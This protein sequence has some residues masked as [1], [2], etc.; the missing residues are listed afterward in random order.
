MTVIVLDEAKLNWLAA[1]HIY[2]YRSGTRPN[3]NQKLSWLPNVEV[4]P[5]VAYLHV[6]V[7]PDAHLGGYA[8]WP[9]GAFSYSFS[10]LPTDTKVGRYCSIATGVKVIGENHPLNRLSSSPFTYDLTHKI[11][12]QACEDLGIGFQS[13]GDPIVPATRNLAPIIN[14]DVWVG[15]DVL[16]GRGITIGNGAV[17]AAGSV[18]TE[19]VPAYAIVGGAPARLIRYRFP[20]Q[21]IE[22]LLSI[23]WWNYAFPD[24]RGIDMASDIQQ[25]LALLEEK[26]NLQEIIPYRPKKLRNSDLLAVSDEPSLSD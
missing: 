4:E 15:A 26:I 16:L 22:Q 13:A 6:E 1:K 3:I 19:N 18:V 8:L 9:M 17:V 20:E 24:F 5:Y 10:F 25:Q 12:S 21:T 23:G 14:H 2:F 11:F 7:R